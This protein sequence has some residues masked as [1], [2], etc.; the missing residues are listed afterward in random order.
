MDKKLRT[1]ILIAIVAI[2]WVYNIYRTYENYQVKEEMASSDTGY[3]LPSFSPLMFNKDSFDLELPGIDPFLKKPSKKLSSNS[4][5]T[6]I[7]QNSIS[8]SKNKKKPP[9]VVVNES[10]QWPSI[11]YFGFVKNRNKENELCLVQI[12]GR[13]HK[14]S[15]GDRFAE[16]LIS[17]VYRDSIQVVFAGEEKTIKKG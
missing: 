5:S 2:V 11:K 16:V 10:V 17:S 9:K 14:L 8:P 15:K 6:G 13:N 7:A 4:V 3:Q 12:N 1:R